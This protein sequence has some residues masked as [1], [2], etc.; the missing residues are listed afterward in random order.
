MSLNL[1]ASKKFK[2]GSSRF[3]FD[4]I[5]LECAQ[6]TF[7]VWLLNRR[8]IQIQFRCSRFV[9]IRWIRPQQFAYDITSCMNTERCATQRSDTAQT[10]IELEHFFILTRT[11]VTVGGCETGRYNKTLISRFQTSSRKRYMYIIYEINIII[12]D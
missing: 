9:L 10:E 4:V 6:A 5:K 12:A 2:S 11:I 8:F 1:R 3:E 7:S